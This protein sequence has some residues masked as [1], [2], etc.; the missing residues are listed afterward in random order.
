MEAA[1]FITIVTFH[2]K[3]FKNKKEDTTD[4]PHHHKSSSQPTSFKPHDTILVLR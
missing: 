4:V 3:P 2:I 1:Y